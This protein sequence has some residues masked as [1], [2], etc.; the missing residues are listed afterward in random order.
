MKQILTRVDDELHA[1]LKRRAE[2]EGRSMNDLVT[3]ALEQAVDEGASPRERLRARAAALGMLAEPSGPVSAPSEL[4]REES[5]QRLIDQLRGAGDAIL[6][7]LEWS[8]GPK[9]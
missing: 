1:R 9:G 2:A 8:R 7:G 6:E 3:R 5:R 4:S